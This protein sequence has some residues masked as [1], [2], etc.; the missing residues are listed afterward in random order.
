MPNLYNMAVYSLIILLILPSIYL[1]YTIY[2]VRIDVGGFTTPLPAVLGLVLNKSMVDKI[3]ERIELT[4]NDIVL[5]YK[6]IYFIYPVTRIYIDNRV[7][8]GSNTTE[9]VYGEF[10]T[11]SSENTSRMD[12]GLTLYKPQNNTLIIIG[13]KHKLSSIYPA[14]KCCKPPIALYMNGRIYRN[15]KVILPIPH[16]I[17]DIS[18]STASFIMIIKIT[19]K[20]Y[21]REDLISTFRTSVEKSEKEVEEV[22]DKPWIEVEAPRKPA[23]IIYVKNWPILYTPKHYICMITNNDSFKGILGIKPCIIYGAHSQT[24]IKNLWI[25]IQTY[26]DEDQLINQWRILVDKLG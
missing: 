23:K 2:G 8:L 25:E 19:S 9:E 6:Y 11:G 22:K 3:L 10:N 7:Y 26:L 12:L 1:S 18:P 17:M 4:L 14:N 5:Q 24:G 16:S 21:V 15:F 20:K 13:T